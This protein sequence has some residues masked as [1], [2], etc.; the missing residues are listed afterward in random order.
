LNEVDSCSAQTNPHAAQVY[1]LADV[2]GTGSAILVVVSFFVRAPIKA[3]LS[4]M[5]G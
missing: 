2:L 5:H 3:C 1:W 4:Q